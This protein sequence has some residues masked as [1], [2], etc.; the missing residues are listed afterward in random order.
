M[1]QV[2]PPHDS[3]DDIADALTVLVD[4]SNGIKAAL[5]AQAETMQRKPQYVQVGRY[6][7]C[8]KHIVSIEDIVATLYVYSRNA[9]SAI[10]RGDDRTAFL[11]WWNEHA[12]VVQLGDARDTVE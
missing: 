5:I 10:L 1:T 4:V 3:L 2:M 9:P 7:I 12:D 6:W 8:P 11:A